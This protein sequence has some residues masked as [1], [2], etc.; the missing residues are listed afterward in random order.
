METTFPP[1]TRLEHVSVMPEPGARFRRDGKTFVLVSC[2]ASRV[3]IEASCVGYESIPR[4]FQGK[5]MLTLHFIE[6]EDALLPPGYQQPK[7]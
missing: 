1:P 6:V 5:R 7:H 4:I 3:G 2:E